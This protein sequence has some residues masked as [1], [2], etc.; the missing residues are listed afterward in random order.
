M[1]SPRQEV[2]AQ[3]SEWEDSFLECRDMGH[4]WAEVNYDPMP[5]RKVVNRSLLCSSCTAERIDKIARKSGEIIGRKYNYPKGYI[6]T[7]QYK[8]GD[9]RKAEIRAE[10]LRRYLGG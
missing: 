9:M 5:D 7:R 6:K 10:V 8:A 3:I 2:Q 1:A 4:T